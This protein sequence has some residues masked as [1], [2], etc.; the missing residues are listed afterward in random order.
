MATPKAGNLSVNE[1]LELINKNK[2][3]DNFCILDIRTPQE[4]ESGII[5]GS[6][7]I[8]YFDK[9]FRK[10]LNNLDKDKVYFIY[11]KSGKRSGLAL[12]I[13]EELQFKEV[14]NMPG[15]MIKWKKAGCPVS[16]ISF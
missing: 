4:I 6:K 9:D 13:M 11:C 1:S 2:G 7:N 14:Y 12:N 15:G 5:E 3:N 16:K 10:K 8:N